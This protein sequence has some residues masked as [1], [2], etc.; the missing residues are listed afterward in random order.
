MKIISQTLHR[1]LGGAV[2]D[3]VWCTNIP[4]EQLDL[5][6]IPE[7]ERHAYL[8]QLFYPCFLQLEL[9]AGLPDSSIVFPEPS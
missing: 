8:Y 3:T 7:E 5:S 9:P 1:V 6:G 4:P 2:G